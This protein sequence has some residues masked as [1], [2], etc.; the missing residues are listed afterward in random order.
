MKA[1][2]ARYQLHD[3]SRQIIKSAI[4]IFERFNHVRNNE[5]LAHDNDL[6][7]HAEARFIFD[8]ITAIL[9]FVKSLEAGRFGT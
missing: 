7:Y 6:L 9:R 5:S 2:E 1:L 3:A 4:G 8:S